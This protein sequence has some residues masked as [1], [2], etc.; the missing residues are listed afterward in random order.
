MLPPTPQVSK[1]MLFSALIKD[2]LLAN[3]FYPRMIF[4]GGSNLSFGLNSQTIKDSLKINPINTA[5]NANISLKYMLD[6]TYQYVKNGDIIV[7]IPEYSHFYRDYNFGSEE[8]LRTILDVRKSNIKLLNINQIINCSP[9]LGRFIISKFYRN[10]YI[11]IQENDIYGV[12]SINK[13]GDTY[14]HWNMDRRKFNPLDS[15]NIY[16][17]NPKV[18]EKIKE[19]EKKIN[20]KG[21]ILFISYPAFQDIS[22]YRSIEAINKIEEEFIKY[23][24][25]ILG[26]PYRY[27]INDSLM[28]NTPYH[29]NKTG[30]DLRT[31]L[32]IEDLKIVFFNKTQYDID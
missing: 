32:L 30:V 14:T 19:F 16:Y 28:F 22:Y 5:I 2:S 3:E 8:L 1:S 26:T 11:N 20:K 29:L 6:N 18:I 4:V 13:Y 21:A 12:N 23:D 15:I 31:Q 10:Q 17:Y 9:F 24:F 25:T 7:V 27:M